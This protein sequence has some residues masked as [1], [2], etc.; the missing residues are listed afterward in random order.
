MKA[1]VL[2][3]VREPLRQQ[4]VSQPEPEA[5]QLL[6]KFP[7]VESVEQICMWWMEN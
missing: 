3:Q 5:G 7:P 1:M 2:R 6:L 4:E